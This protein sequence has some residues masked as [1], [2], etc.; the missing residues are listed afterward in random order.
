MG[1]VAHDLRLSQNPGVN[2]HESPR[3]SHTVRESRRAKHV[4]LRYSLRGGLE[5]VVPPGFDRG[6]IPE[7]LRAKERW[8]ARVERELADER[9]HLDPSP[10]DRL[11][12]TIELRAL[13]ESWVVVA[14]PGNG[15]RV[16]VRETAGRLSV[17]GPTDRPDL[18]RRALKTWLARRARAALGEWVTREASAHRLRHGPISIRWQKSRWGSCSRRGGA[19]AEVPSTLSFNAGL[20]FLPPHLV[21]YVLLHEL[22]HTT[23]MDHSPAFWRRLESIEPRASVLRDELR[24]AWRYLPAWLEDSLPGPSA[25]AAWDNGPAD[26]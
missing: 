9:R 4:H 11:P 22:C 25:D 20:L 16:R 17:A 1:H 23:R 10:P 3:V 26:G 6:E 21:R 13:D 24:L 5:V 7:L 2:S 8:I 15:A 19:A 12:E 18:W 14:E